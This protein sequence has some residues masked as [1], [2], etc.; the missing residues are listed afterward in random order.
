MVIINDMLTLSNAGYE[1][2]RVMDFSLISECYVNKSGVLFSGIGDHRASVTS[3][4][5]S[6]LD[7]P[8]NNFSCFSP[9]HFPL[10]ITVV[11]SEM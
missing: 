3:L 7:S 11:T 4:M 10:V 5:P 1:L 6:H 8:S 9:L 2:T